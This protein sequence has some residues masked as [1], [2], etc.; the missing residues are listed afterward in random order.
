MKI[1]TINAY[2]VTLPFKATFSHSQKNA[3]SVDNIVVEI[4]PDERGPAGYGE[5]GP[6]PYVT[7]ETQDSA[8]RGVES[9]CQDEQFPWDL[10]DVG[11]IWDFVTAAIG[12]KDHNSALCALEIALLDVLARNEGQNILHYLPSDHLTEEIRYGATVP[13]SDQATV[14]K[15]C[16]M[17][18]KLDINEVRLKMGR[19]F[20]QNQGVLEASRQAL[21]SG[22]DLRVDVNG[23]W[24]L[25]LTKQHL[26]LIESYGVKVLEQPLPPNDRGWEDLA[27][28]FK[29][30][31]L[32]F[33]ADESVCSMEDMKKAVIEGYFDVI[34]VRLSKCGGFHNSLKIIRLIRDAGIDYQV[35]CQLGES[36]ILSAAGRA[37]CA[38]SSDALYYDGSYDAFLLKENLTAEHVTF[39]HGGKAIP[40]KGPGLGIRVNPENLKRFSDGAIC[41]RRP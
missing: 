18:Q 27:G 41:I 21:G 36:G 2:K 30:N 5:G 38:I 11:E 19:D 17:L 3:T 6:R 25:K 13:I 9:L 32:K 37:L 22:C 35:G 40:L 14:L 31:N 12:E 23:A 28:V 39:N 29:P 24:D 1:R 8:I 34:N 16:K 7:G 26:P 20:G 10:N 15:I 4:L 33:M